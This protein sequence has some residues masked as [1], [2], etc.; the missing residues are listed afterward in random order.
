MHAWENRGPHGRTLPRQDGGTVKPVPFLVGA[1]GGFF[2]SAMVAVKAW[3]S[4]M[5]RSVIMAGLVSKS[6]LSQHSLGRL[7]RQFRIAPLVG[8]TG[9]RRRFFITSDSIR[10]W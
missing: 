1:G 6:A 3:S 10:F 2:F 7:T 8:C 5:A 9:R 4:A